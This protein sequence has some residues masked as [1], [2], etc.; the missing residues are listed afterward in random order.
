[1][2]GENGNNNFD[3]Q[4]YG[5]FL[6]GMGNYNN[7]QQANGLPG[8]YL[9]GTGLLG[10]AAMGYGGAMQGA[11]GQM[12]A[13]L[14]AAG[15]AANSRFGM[16]VS[17]AGSNPY[18][19]TLFSDPKYLGEL[20]QANNEAQRSGQVQ[21]Q[22]LGGRLGAVNNSG[23]LQTL[24]GGGGS[25]GGAQGNSYSSPYSYVASNGQ[26]NPIMAGSPAGYGISGTSGG[27]G[28][29]YF[30]P[31]QGMSN[32]YAGVTQQPMVGG[33]RSSIPQTTQTNYYGPNA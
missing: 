8:G 6:Q 12:G 11:M 29:S 21:N 3:F 22:L 26:G 27:Q 28:Y 25:N 10:Q 31:T 1:M 20:R 18:N 4:G 30:G 17:A 19:A 16:Q 33:S 5:N 23:L 9:G 32:T 7:N 24:M 15:D 13:G 14:Q 2:A